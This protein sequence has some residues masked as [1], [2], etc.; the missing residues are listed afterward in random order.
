MPLK[1]SAIIISLFI[2][3]S[4]QCQQW[5]P[6]SKRDST[7][8]TIRLKSGDTVGLRLS[9]LEVDARFPGGSPAWNDYIKT[10]LKTSV[11]ADNN[12]PNGT[13]RVVVRFIIAKDGTISD[14]VAETKHGYGMEAELMRIIKKAPKFITAMKGGKAVSA[15]KRQQVT[16]VVNEHS[17]MFLH[18]SQ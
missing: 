5:R 13:Y 14:V 15:F 18:L 4:V 7:P 9:S 6:A 10:N 12:A 1:L 3:L 17:S 16:F 8:K 2:S 11:A